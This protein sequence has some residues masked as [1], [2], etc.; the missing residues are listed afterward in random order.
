MPNV[1]PVW[2]NEVPLLGKIK[3]CLLLDEWWWEVRKTDGTLFAFGY[4]D[5]AKKAKHTARE[6]SLRLIHEL[7]A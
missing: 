6:A 5:D 4:E 1:W 3:V 2:M 7:M